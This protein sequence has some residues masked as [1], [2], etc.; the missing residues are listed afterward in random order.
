MSFE[1][2][3]K[4]APKL[5]QLRE[6][7]NA[8]V[9]YELMSGGLVWSDE[10]PSWDQL[11]TGESHC[12]RAVW[13]FRSSLIMGTPEEKHRASWERAQE[14]FPDWPGF[15]PQRRSAIWRETFMEQRTKLLAEWEDLDRRF[16]N[17]RCQTKEKPA[18]A[19]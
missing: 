19:V 14:V 12:L 2:L 1:A 11:E 5:N 17:S 8:R 3:D 13:R 18:S 15:L 16:E 4:I 6:D 7:P 10:L 9:H